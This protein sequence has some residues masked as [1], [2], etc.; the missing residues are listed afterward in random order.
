MP[1]SNVLASPD[2]LAHVIDIDALILSKTMAR[3]FDLT[4]IVA[5][6]EAEQKQ[7]GS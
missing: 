2:L 4:L 7:N 6:H 1:C 5:T 3:Y